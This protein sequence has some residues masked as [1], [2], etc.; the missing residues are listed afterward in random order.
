MKKI[1]IIIIEDHAILRESLGERL[2]REDDIEVAG[3]W[4]SGEEALTA[5]NG[6]KF[7]VGIIDNILPGMD[8]IETI[9]KLRQMQP[10]AKMIILSMFDSAD[11]VVDAFDAGAVGFLPKE[12]YV[13][14]LIKAIRSVIAGETV[15]PEKI[16][17]KILGFCTKLK[18]KKNRQEQLSEEH[19][20]IL[21]YASSGFTNK[22]I[23]RE[24]GF[25]IETVKFR[26]KEIFGIL[27]TK[28]RTHAVCKAI[29]MGLIS[30][31]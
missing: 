7:D 21:K 13:K 10:G 19:I 15:V 18:E 4:S 29:S 2:G 31:S 17:K 9:K 6:R 27:G 3:L 26:F 16:A 28:D 25:S 14:E 11:N 23:A 12:V 1:R 20:R 8:G 30:L 22:E 24:I 5:L